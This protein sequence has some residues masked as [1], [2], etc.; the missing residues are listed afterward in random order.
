MKETVKTI[1]KI[2]SYFKTEN[3]FL[4]F[5]GKMIGNFQT[6][7][8]THLVDSIKNIIYNRFY[9]RNISEGKSGK[10]VTAI[11]SRNNYFQHPETFRIKGKQRQKCMLVESELQSGEGLYASHEGT[12][13]YIPLMEAEKVPSIK[14]DGNNRYIVVKPENLPVVPPFF[15]HSTNGW[16]YFLNEYK[17]RIYFNCNP[18]KVKFLAETIIYSMEKY[19]I[20]FAFKCFN[21]DEF[22]NRNDTAVLYLRIVDFNAA[23]IVIEELYN[24]IKNS[25][26]T[27]V[28]LFTLKLAPGISFA[29]SPLGGVS[30]GEHRCFAIARSIYTVFRKNIPDENCLSELIKCMSHINIRIS[31]MHLN[32]QSHYS[33]R[34]PLLDDKR[35]KK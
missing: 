7:A 4:F 23:A 5:S 12:L 9:C 20:P 6:D 11:K 30:F 26:R 22:Y 13:C 34:F 21:S 29:E 32:S 14:L 18:S 16:K 19:E 3:S 31:E 35:N 2:L 1:G 27:G 15:Y 28:P 17:V 8:E 24:S 33:Y 10:L 25:L